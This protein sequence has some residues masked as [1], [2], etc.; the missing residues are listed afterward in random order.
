MQK[1]N[2]HK[3]SQKEPEKRLEKKNEKLAGHPSVDAARD[4]Q[5][6]RDFQRRKR[7]GLRPLPKKDIKVILRLHK[8][9]TVKSL[10][11]L[12][13][14]MAVIEACR[15]SFEGENFLLRVHAG[16]N[17][18]ILSTLHKQ[19]AGRLREISQ[20]KIRGQIHLFNAYVANPE[21]VLRD[22]V[23]GLLPRTTQADLMANLQI[24]RQ[25]VKI[26]SPGR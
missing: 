2:N 12:E 7:R 23:H 21:D 10:F 17:I 26:V 8:G 19:V 6:R 9:F 5:V 4:S 16:S 14:S 3:Q 18:I 11:G 15:K 25:G 20:L 13:L 24:W 1:K 22:I